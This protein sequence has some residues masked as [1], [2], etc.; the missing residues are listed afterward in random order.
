MPR[1][2]VIGDIHGALK[3]LQQLLL[4]VALQPDDQ[5]MFLGDYVDG[6]SQS[7]DVIAY[8]I[9]LEKRQSCIFIK[10]NH[11]MCCSSWLAENTADEE[12]LYHGGKSTVT[13]YLE[14]STEQKAVH[15]DFFN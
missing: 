1:K 6:W 8:L 10:G 13:N 4:S 3:A 7:A 11:D 5:L 14:Y 9:E 15:L 2:I 12:W